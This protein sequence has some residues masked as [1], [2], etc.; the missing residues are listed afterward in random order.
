MAKKFF[1]VN[2]NEHKYR[3]FMEDLEKMVKRTKKIRPALPQFSKESHSSSRKDSLESQG[4]M[5]DE[6][7]G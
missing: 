5:S 6:T 1:T 4:K 3:V 7:E 2:V